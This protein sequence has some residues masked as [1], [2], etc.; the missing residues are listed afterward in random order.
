M[1]AT[2]ACA[3]CKRTASSLSVLVH[4][5][6]Q[7]RCKPHRQA[8]TASTQQAA[9][10]CWLTQELNTNASHTGD[11]SC[12]QAGSSTGMSRVSLPRQGVVEPALNNLQACAHGHFP[13]RLSVK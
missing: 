2:Q 5:G 11:I 9:R 7:H 10:P 8:T 6:A 4:A 13:E 12:E 3:S 1:Q